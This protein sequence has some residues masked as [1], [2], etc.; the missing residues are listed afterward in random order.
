MY[1]SSLAHVHE[2]SYLGSEPSC[3]LQSQV[4][5]LIDLLWQL[6]VSVAEV[7]CRIRVDQVAEPNGTVFLAHLRADSVSFERDQLLESKV[8]EIQC[9]PPNIRLV[10]RTGGHCVIV[11]QRWS[12]WGAGKGSKS[13]DLHR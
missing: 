12:Y 8:S 11:E 4:L 5:L 9:N 13:P 2:D 10:V 1:R 7:G 3:R 6:A